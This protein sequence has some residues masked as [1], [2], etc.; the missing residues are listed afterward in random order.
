MRKPV[1]G[2]MG[3]GDVSA[4]VYALAER[5]GSL[6]AGR[7]WVLLNGGRDVGVMAASAKGAREVGGTVI[8]ILPGR[9]GVEASPDLDFAIVT[10]LNDARNLI[11][12]LSSDVVVA[13]PGGAGTLSEVAL[14]LKNHKPVVLLGPASDRT[15]EAFFREYARRG[16]LHFAHSAEEAV[17]V[18]AKTLEST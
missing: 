7:G 10:G 2:V 12:V 1:V 6:I 11:N 15:A 3:G 5:L 4:E 14:A 17:E 13:C 9:D 8:G 18:V 16:Q